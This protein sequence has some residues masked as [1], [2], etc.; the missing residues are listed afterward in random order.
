MLAI[1]LAYF[2][3]PEVL[4]GTPGDILRSDRQLNLNLCGCDPRNFS[5]KSNFRASDTLHI[6]ERFTRVA[7]DRL[8]YE[9]A[10]DDPS[11]WTAPW[12]VMIPLRH[13]SDQI[14]EYACHEGNTGLYSILAG[15]REEEKGNGCRGCGG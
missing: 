10:L 15:E 6:V 12:S 14:Y 7:P 8:K 1:L 13:S 5:P 4:V 9:L 11:T 2:D 3:F